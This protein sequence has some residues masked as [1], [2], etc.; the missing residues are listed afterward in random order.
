MSSCPFCEIDANRIFYESHLVVGLWDAFPV[1]PG[2]ALLVTRRHVASW[3]DASSGERAELLDGIVAARK[4]IDEHH[5]PDGYNIG[6]NVGAAAGQTVAHL[7]LHVIPRRTGDV[8]NPRGGVRF[9]IP[10]KADYL[11]GDALERRTV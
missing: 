9:V 4:A 11:G 3:F 6:V 10:A 5:A 1:S 7:H 8:P 2:H